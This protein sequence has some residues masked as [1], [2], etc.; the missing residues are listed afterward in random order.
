M[1]ENTTIIHSLQTTLGKMEIALSAIH[2]A[3][4]WTN[5][6]NIIQ[7]C[8]RAFDKMVSLPH[9]N[10]LG[11]DITR[12]FP[13]SHNGRP[14]PPDQYPCKLLLQDKTVNNEIYQFNCRGKNSFLEISGNITDYFSNETITILTVRNISSLRQSQLDLK[15]VKESLE[16]SVKKRTEELKFLTNKYKSILSEAVD[17]IITI[18]D[19]GEVL[20]FNPAAEQIFGYREDEII[21]ENVSLLMP[22][23]YREKHNQF[24]KN[25]LTTG[26]KKIIGI[27][28]R[29]V[30]ALRRSG[31]PF[32]IDL[33]VSEVRLKDQ[34][35][36]TGIL[37][38]ITRRKE[39]E[40]AL[41]K[42]KREAEEANRAKSDFLASMSHEIR[43]PLNVIL[44]MADLLEETTL[45]QQQD[46]YIS[47]FKGAGEHLLSIINDLLDLAKIEADQFSL[48]TVS[49]DLTKLLSETYALMLNSAQEKELEFTYSLPSELPSKI[50][51]DPKRLRQV[52]INLLGNAIKFTQKGSV[53]LCVRSASFARDRRMVEFEFEVKDTGI[54]IPREKL[55]TVFHSFSQA[56]RNI[57][58]EFG[59]SGLGLA[60]SKSLVAL[61]GGDISVKS[62]EH[63]GSTFTF[64]A[65]FRVMSEENAQDKSEMPEIRSSKVLH[66]FPGPVRIL[67]AEDSPENR[68][69]FQAYLK[70]ADC[71]LE[72]AEN[73]QI[74]VEKFI[75]NGFDL[76]L[77][78]I[79]MPVLDGYSAAKAIRS[80]EQ[81]R[82]L[83]PIPIIA[84]TAYALAEEREKSIQSG[85]T[86]HV[87]KPISKQ[88]FLAAIQKVIRENDI[89]PPPE[90]EDSRPLQTVHIDRMLEDLIPGFLENRRNDVIAI[91]EAISLGDMDKIEH[92]GH[93]MKGTGGGYGFERITAIG[94]DIENAA[95]QKRI[96][97]LLQLT[98]ELE[99]FVNTVDIVFVD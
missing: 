59:G 12:I 49:F 48:D 92:L 74:A 84:L 34:V 8:N 83:P 64:N 41:E 4:V 2:E 97:M 86:M 26:I 22:S 76:I 11:A 93:T 81:Q 13:L 43:T 94:K 40:A 91:R 29:E 54:G 35:I 31:Q 98:E 85:C 1:E 44:G 71:T 77:M 18:N 15:I 28:G 7:W 65:W 52:L 96:D 25:Y 50:I 61:M 14:V 99:N 6:K 23:P 37:R 42:A 78:D 95:K 73:G 45:S 33:A 32:P 88:D 51:G 82:K 36:F 38:D 62:Q 57:T 3:I 72:F 17:A 9:I 56:D 19:L 89:S 30:T 63:A 58:R 16:V 21:G 75:A 79:Q 87:V 46:E 20:S 5:E 10:V 53:S 90:Q 60:V 27:G 47:I 70:D 80:H 66:S 67:L 69:L 24:I 68:F 55:E 39:V